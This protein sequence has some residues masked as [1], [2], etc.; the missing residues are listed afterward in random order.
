[1]CWRVAVED[2]AGDI[3]ED[4][5]GGIGG[6]QNMVREGREVVRSY[7]LTVVRASCELLLNFRP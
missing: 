2:R 4:C 6:L 1:M 3:S 5:R 7:G